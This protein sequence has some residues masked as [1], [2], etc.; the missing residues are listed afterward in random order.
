MQPYV[1]GPLTESLFGKQFVLAW[2]W[3]API[4]GLIS[5]AV[6]MLGKKNN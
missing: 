4:G 6:C 1:M 3:W 5:T 2:S